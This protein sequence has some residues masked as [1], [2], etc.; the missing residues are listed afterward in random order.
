MFMNMNVV[1]DLMT[2]TTITPRFIKMQCCQVFGQAMDLTSMVWFI[3]MC[4]I[5]HQHKNNM[6]LRPHMG[7]NAINQGAI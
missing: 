1:W 2:C 6:G 3:K 7:A 4:L 5:V